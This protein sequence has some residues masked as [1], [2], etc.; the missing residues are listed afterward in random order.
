MLLKRM[1]L[2]MAVVAF[3]GMLALAQKDS[4]AA[5]ALER[6]TA[7]AGFSP[8]DLSGFV[9]AGTF[10]ALRAPQQV[11]RALT[12]KV[13]GPD[14]VRWELAGA[15]GPVVTVV[16]GH[17]GWTR[18]G[19]RTRG[20]S[21]AE[22]AT[23]GSALFPLPALGE[24]ISSPRS[25]LGAP[26]PDPMG[27]GPALT[28][29]P[30]SLVPQVEVGGEAL[31]AL[32]TISRLELLTETGSGLVAGVEVLDRSAR[33]WRVGTPLRV[34][35]SDPVRVDGILLPSILTGFRG[36]EALWRIHFDSIQVNPD[37]SPEDFLP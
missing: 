23:R 13:L 33:D 35:F 15:D 7:A 16:A 2:A 5:R 17:S 26:A 31:E 25:R 8:G 1:G 28:R 37:L 29:I 20:L 9:A 30:V 24:W 22:A 6:A 32:E 36:G 3:C 34:L 14:R 19:G 10:T 11:P 27:G 12:V 4:A 18:S 21:A